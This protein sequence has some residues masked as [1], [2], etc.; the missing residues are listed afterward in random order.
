MKNYSYC[1]SRLRVVP[2]FPQGSGLLRDI[3]EWAKLECAWKS[4]HARKARRLRGEREKN[5]GLQT[6]PKLLT[7]Q[8]RMIL[9]CEVRI[10]FRINSAHPMRFLPSN[11]REYLLQVKE[12]PDTNFLRGCFA[13]RDLNSVKKGVGT[14][15]TTFTHGKMLLVPVNC[16]LWQIDY[17]LEENGLTEQMWF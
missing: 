9:E 17:A 13:W 12:N 2:I 7:F 15:Q 4:P 8:G 16:F 3:V 10:T 14:Q 6:K 5:E 11:C 1:I